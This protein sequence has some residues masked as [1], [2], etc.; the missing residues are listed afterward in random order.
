MA[1]S[2][3]SPRLPSL[4]ADMSVTSRNISRISSLGGNAPSRAPRSGSD[5]AVRTDHRA[6]PDEELR[7]RSVCRLA[8]AHRGSCAEDS[9]LRVCRRRALRFLRRQFRQDEYPSAA[10]PQHAYS[11]EPYP[12]S[13]PQ[14]VRP[15]AVPAVRRGAY[16]AF[17]TARSDTDGS[18]VRNAPSHRIHSVCSDRMRR[19]GSDGA[20][21]PMFCCAEPTS[22]PAPEPARRASSSR[23]MP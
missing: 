9:R 2:R 1:I 23:T 19:I 15:S 10:L 18:A 21:P 4:R 11:A 20:H 14:A 8:R 3:S 16:P 17:Q 12:H 22:V 5:F 6:L 13:L 7:L